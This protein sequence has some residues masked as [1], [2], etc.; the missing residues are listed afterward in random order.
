MRKRQLCIIYLPLLLWLVLVGSTGVGMP[1]G[2]SRPWPAGDTIQ[3]E[4][5]VYRQELKGSSQSIYLKNISVLSKASQNIEAVSEYTKKNVVVF[6]KENQWIEIGNIV[7][8]LGICA[9]PSLPENPGGFDAYG[10]YGAMD[11]AM[12][13]KKAVVQKNDHRADFF[14]QFLSTVRKKASESLFNVFNSEDA[15]ILSAMLLGEKNGLDRELKEL[16]QDNGIIHILAISGLHISLLGMALY[17][18]LRKIG[19]SFA[20]ASGVSGSILAAYVL[21]TGSAASSLRAWIMFVI[22]LGAQ[23][24]GRT[25]DS[26]TALLSAAVVML[27]HNPK[28]VTQAGFLLSFAAVAAVNLSAHFTHPMRKGK[29]LGISLSIFLVT[30]PVVAWFYYRI[31]VYGIFL[32]VIVIP[33]M[34]I[35]LGAG[36][37]SMAVGMCS[38]KIGIFFAAPAHYVLAGIRFLCGRVR[39]L[40]GNTLVLGRPKPI[41]IVVYYLILL[42]LLLFFKKKR[43]IDLLTRAFGIIL[44]ISIILYKEPQKWTMT[45]LNVG[46]GDGCCIRTEKRAVWMIDAGSSDHQELAAYSLCPYLE[47]HGI[48]EVDYWMISHYDNDHVSGL[49]EILQSYQKDAAGR[50]ACGITVKHLILPDIGRGETVSEKESVYEKIVKL[51][52]QNQIQ[53]LYAGAGDVIR[54]GETYFRVLAPKRNHVYKNHNEASMVVE[55]TYKGFRALLTGDVEGEG[56]EALLKEGLLGDVDLLKVAHHGSGNSTKEEFIEQIK[57]EVSVISCG[58]GN[59]YGH[60]HQELL[61]RLEAAKSKIVRTDSV[62]AV[63]VIVTE[64]GYY[65]AKAG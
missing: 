26:P 5:T 1:D 16:Y 32:N 34:P 24:A 35:I 4:G 61:R 59:R 65:V 54:Q 12:T 19:V 37:V 25:Y 30:L 49:M 10:Y 33:M 62:G 14:R 39:M 56:E 48:D 27:L 7:Q 52:E 58:A 3:V 63:D 29:S 36:A 60:P 22:F 6:L 40:P 46:Q 28:M 55:V 57:P 18:L 11:I 9:Y 41:Q 20:G 2:A 53:V 43:K 45:F 15:G 50:N 31:P 17:Y 64:Q 13:I 23:I 47:Y 51:A 21:M 38:V 42:I 8:V 44:I